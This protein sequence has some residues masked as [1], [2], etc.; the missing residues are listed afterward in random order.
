MVAR[1]CVGSAG[2]SSVHTPVG[3]RCSPHRSASN[4]VIL[5]VSAPYEG[6]NVDV[7][8]TL[9]VTECHIAA[10]LHRNQA[11]CPVLCTWKP[12]VMSHCLTRASSLSDHRMPPHVCLRDVPLPQSIKRLFWATGT[13]ASSSPSVLNIALKNN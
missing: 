7:F 9:P 10:A 12:A 3:L 4:A 13:V 8:C 6:L 1:E 11:F 5:S 2:V